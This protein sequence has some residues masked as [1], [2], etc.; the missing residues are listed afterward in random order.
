[1]RATLGY[2]VQDL[3]DALKGGDEI[4]VADAEKKG[5]R[6]LHPGPQRVCLHERVHGAIPTP[7]SDPSA[8]SFSRMNS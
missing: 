7:S 4:G 1:V 5:H 8:K 2:T 3:T 6:L